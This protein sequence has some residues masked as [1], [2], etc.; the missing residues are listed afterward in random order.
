MTGNKKCLKKM[1]EG[2][3]SAIGVLNLD[4]KKIEKK[5]EK[6]LAF[7]HI[8]FMCCANGPQCTCLKELLF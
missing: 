6:H 8:M 1:K 3:L 2:R 5:E 7:C 4:N